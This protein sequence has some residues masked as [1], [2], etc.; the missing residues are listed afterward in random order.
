M[1][2]PN[3]GADDRDFSAGV[4]VPGRHSRRGLPRP[5]VHRSSTPRKGLRA[6]DGSGPASLIY[7]I[8]ITIEKLDPRRWR[9]VKS[10]CTGQVGSVLELL[11]GRFDKSVM[12][13]L[14]NREKGLFPAPATDKV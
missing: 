10:Q 12:A 13:I 1:T 5:A 7:H 11:Q 6:L 2:D 9:T 14:T 3:H 4:F 8:T